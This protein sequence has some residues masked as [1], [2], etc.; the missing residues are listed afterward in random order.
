MEHQSDISAAHDADRV[1]SAAELIGRGMS[2]HR[3]GELEEAGELYALVLRKQ[4]QHFSAL[5]LSALVAYQ[6]RRL[7]EAADF[8]VKALSLNQ[9]FAPAHSNYGLALQDLKRIDEAIASYD[10]AILLNPDYARAYYN[11]ASALHELERYEE[12]VADYAKAVA[13]DPAYADAFNNCGIALQ[14]MKRFSEA[15]LNYERAIAIKRDFADAFYN[16]GNA[17]FALER[18]EEAIASFDQSLAIRNDHPETLL[19]RANAVQILGRYEDALRDYD[20]VV[21]LN[22][23][24][25]E[26]YYNRGISLQKLER[27][28]EAIQD[29]DKAIAIKPD[30]AEAYNNRGNVLQNLKRFNEALDDYRHALRLRP[31]YASA[32]FNHGAALQVMKNFDEALQSYA[33]AIRIDPD[34]LDA[35]NNRGN[36]FQHLKRVDEAIESY[37]RV[38]TINPDYATARLAKGFALLSRQNLLEGWR[39]YEWRKRLPEPYG[40]RSFGK[41]LWDGS[42][43]V[44]GKK[45]LVHF[46]QGL[47]DTIQF[48]RYLPYLSARGAKVLFAPQKSLRKLM[49][50]LE[51]DHDLVDEYDPST[52]HDFHIPLLSLPLALWGEAPYIPARDSYLRVDD[53][54]LEQWRRRLGSGGFKIGVCWQGSRA[55]IDAGR[56]F[57]LAQFASISAIPGV[58]LISLHKGDGE[59]QLEDLPDGM[60]VETLGPDFDSGPDAFLD[61]AAVM[62][63]CDLVITSDTAVAHLAGALGVK[64]WIVLKYVPDWRWFIDLEASPWYPSVRLFRQPADGDWDGV[65]DQIKGKLAD[66]MKAR[67]NSLEMDSAAVDHKAVFNK[68]YDINLW[69][70]GSGAGSTADNTAQYRAFLGHFMASNKVKSVVDLGC[71]DWQFSKL[72][73]WSGVQYTGIDVSDV[74]LRNTR[75]Y[76][77]EN[78][79]FLEL[80]GVV[81]DLP[82]GELLLVKDVLQHWSNSDII[83][84]FPKL[85]KYDR[86][87]ITN[88]FHPSGLSRLNADISTGGWRPIDLKAPPFNLPGDYIYWYSGGEPK[89]VFLWR[90]SS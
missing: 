33:E 23:D 79:S 3:R 43:D 68:I 66:S 67:G 28:D 89:W 22:P 90:R 17:L 54:R 74:V 9:D 70:N 6:L 59:S 10:R 78:I 38:L 88:G 46:E 12:A 21:R 84:F 1:E 63:C 80:N 51:G 83:S 73:N 52:V 29:Y 32:W 15:L 25:A 86:A 34:Y 55:K 37:D 65:F 13:I 18:F 61:T 56:S 40:D 53:A 75:A 42:Q 81:D 16:R 36:I 35:H 31:D 50:S 30:Y 2:L 64:T 48:C 44:S 14:K 11:R 4:P 71:G 27:H 19:Q 76:S 7:D 39:L 8:F 58:R 60:K 85:Q 72:M 62:K 77:A 45:V 5:H 20:L 87:L 49:S 57:P 82:G 41:P 24:Y 69:G 26:A 47:G